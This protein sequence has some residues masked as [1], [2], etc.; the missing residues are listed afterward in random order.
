MNKRLIY[1]LLWGLP[2]IL[3][4]GLLWNY[5]VPSGERTVRYEMG[6]I[7]PFVQ[8][9][10]PDDRVS[11]VATTSG[12]NYVTLLD[13][14][15]YFSVTPPSGNFTS[16]NVEVL[17]DPGETPT[18][19][20]GGLQDVAAQA[21]D[22]R[23]L[24]NTLLEELDWTRHELGGGL[25]VFSRDPKSYAYQTFLETP[26][27]RSIVAT[28]RA[29]FPTPYRLPEYVPLGVR[30]KFDVSLRGPHELLTY[31]KNEN[32]DFKIMFTDVN[33]T[34]GADEGFVRVYDE[35][36]NLM[37]EFVIRDDGNIYDNQEPSERTDVELYGRGWPEGVY[38]ITLSGTSDII[39]R[40]LETSQR[41]LVAKNRVF[42]GDDV[43]Y[44]PAPRPTSLYTNA[45]RVTLETQHQEGLQTVAIGEAS[46]VVDQVGAKYSRQ[47]A[48]NGVATL[49]SPVGDI[50]ITGEGKYAFNRQSFFDPDPVSLT[51][52]TDL[53][54][55]DIEHVLANLTPVN[56]VEGWRVA[57][58]EFDVSAL[59]QEN[60][61][62]K[63][64]LSAPGIHDNL[65]QVSVHAIH[66]T[67]QKPAASLDT[68][69]ADLKHFVKLLLP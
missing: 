33:R 18:F 55:S 35:L 22:F 21:F 44:L 6:G 43:G 32:F 16:V 37:T 4:A 61:A 53:E 62:Y 46:I 30:Q 67:F 3:F 19:E 59:A 11:E 41:Y 27:D 58:A 8:R 5:F 54:N 63:F 66:V 47:I 20:I 25:A 12:G 34:Y 68:L 31:I 15:V 42:I 57:S 45:Q 2:V 9:L 24:A 17:F 7:S 36:G 69:F 48:S 26:P 38:R 60:G 28:Y 40:S 23:P 56:S 39:W 29:T 10:L 51:A 14:P 65:G 64:A 49:Y 52:F 13:E 50:K 1:L